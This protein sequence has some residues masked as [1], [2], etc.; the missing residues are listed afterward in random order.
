MRIG[1]LAKQSGF[2]QSRIRFYEQKGLISPTERTYSG[3]RIYDEQALN[4]L[5]KIKLCKQLGFSLDD[6]VKLLG[7]QAALNHHAL[8][9]TLAERKLEVEA[10]IKELQ[11]NHQNI[12]KLEQR[13]TQLWQQDECMSDDELA[14]IVKSTTF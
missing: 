12:S 4:R 14:Q 1:Q 2:S 7:E 11:F 5:T 13:L 8:F 6:I 9:E 10:L 3:Y